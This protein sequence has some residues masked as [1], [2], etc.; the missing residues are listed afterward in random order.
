[1]W[2]EKEGR[3]SPKNKQCIIYVCDLRIQTDG[4]T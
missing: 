4:H 1:M 3:V 2:Q